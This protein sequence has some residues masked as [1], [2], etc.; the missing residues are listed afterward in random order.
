MR[1]VREGPDSGLLNQP[2]AFPISNGIL[3]KEIGPCGLN[4][5]VKAGGIVFSITK[6]SRARPIRSAIPVR[7][8][9]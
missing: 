6:R 1:T 8:I 9:Q 5:Y 4:R 7:K 3:H 2:W